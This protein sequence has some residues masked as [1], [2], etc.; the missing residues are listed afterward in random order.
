MAKIDKMFLKDEVK[1]AA[2]HPKRE[3]KWIHYTK[4]VDHQAQYCNEKSRLEIESLADLIDADKGVTQN[5]L[6]RKADT[7]EYE[8]IAGHKRRRACKLL[9][10]ERGKK[11]Y[12]FLPCT[13]EHLTDVQAEFQLYSS[14]RFH[15]KDDYEKMHE[16]ERMKYLLEAHPE[17]FP[18][19]Q[20]GRMVERL[21]KQ[22]NL[23]RTTVGEYLTIA[24]NLGKKGKEEFQSGNIKK[25]AAVE[26]AALPEKEQEEL[27]AQGVTSH[28]EIKAY[29]EEKREQEEKNKEAEAQ[30]IGQYKVVN[31]DMDIEED[32]PESGTQNPVKENVPKSGTQNPAEEDVPKSGTQENALNCAEINSVLEKSGYTVKKVSLEN[33]KSSQGLKIPE[34]E[35]KE[36]LETIEAEELEADKKEQYTPKFFM[37]EQKKKLDE[38]LCDKENGR[39]I[40]EKALARQKLIVC[41]MEF[42]ISRMVLE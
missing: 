2:P 40:P 32:V 36:K 21:A 22:M 29:K 15:D 1:K 24:K 9:V 6:V 39:I 31:T 17:E 10:E 35:Q 38:M 4:L 19:L 11:Q 8:I 30:I 26:L 25:S 37:E 14:N 12:E 28:K 3:T 23:K 16:L 33:M 13:I 20:T 18:H 41:A 34:A 7:D 42:Y 27:L 5:L